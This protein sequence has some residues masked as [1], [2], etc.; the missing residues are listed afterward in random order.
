VENISKTI[1][2]KDDAKKLGYVLDVVW[3]ENALA[4]LGYVVVDE[5]SENEFFVDLKDVSFV[6]ELGF[7][8]DPS[9]MQFMSHR[10]SSLIGKT[11]LSSTGIDLGRVEAVKSFRNRCLKII[12][13]KCEVKARFVKMVGEDYVVLGK[14]K[15]ETRYKSFPKAKGDV[16]VTILSSPKLEKPEKVSLS[17][18][19]YLGKISGQD[20][21]GYNNERIVVRGEKISKATLEKVKKHNKLN[22]L[23]FAIKN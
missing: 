21:L 5:E 4:L 10:K 7:V 6:G 18:N 17:T 1:V 14:R 9:V 22:E 20:I 15:A 12:T 19:Y 3:D 16:E 11:V 8:D 23:F 2:S 13:D